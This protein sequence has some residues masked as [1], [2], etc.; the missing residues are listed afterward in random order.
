MLQ[1]NNLQ[2]E[3]SESDYRTIRGQSNLNLMNLDNLVARFMSDIPNEI[4]K[5]SILTDRLS[6]LTV[7]AGNTYFFNKGGD[8]KVVENSG[9]DFDPELN[10]I[11]LKPNLSYKLEPKEGTNKLITDKKVRVFNTEKTKLLS[12][13]D[14]LIR[15]VPINIRTEENNYKY[16]LA[17]TFDELTEYNNIS[18][19]LNEKTESYPHITEVYYINSRREK[20]SVKILNN[21]LYDLDLDLVK[22]SSNIYSIDIETISA[23]NIYI[24]LEDNLNELI[25][26]KLHINYMEYPSK[27]SI[28]F[29]AIREDKP[30][31][32]VG[33]ESQGTVEASKLELSYNNKDWVDIDISNTYAL[34]KKSKVIAYNTINADSIKTETDVKVMYLRV[35]LYAISEV[36]TPTAKVDRNTYA[37]GEFDT[38]S[39]KYNSYSLYEN[40]TGNFYGYL[41]NQNRF[42]FNDFYDHGEYLIIDNRYYAKGFVETEF[43]KTKESQYIYAP[44]SLKTKEIKISGDRVTFNHI[45]ISTKEV[46]STQTERVEKNLVDSSGL[47]FVIPLKETAYNSVYYLRQ[48]TKEIEVNLS[49]GHINSAIDVLY[50]VGEGD[51]FLLDS[52]KNLV[53]KLEVKSYKNTRYVSLLDTNLFEEMENLSRLYPIEPLKDYETGLIDNQ[54]ESINRD[55]DIVGYVLTT[56]K[57]YTKDFIS[58]KNTNYSEIISDD[59]YKRSFTTHTEMVSKYVKQQKLLKSGIV[60]GSIAIEGVLE[61]PFINGYTEFI[62]HFSRELTIE[63]R[64]NLTHEVELNEPKVLDKTFTYSFPDNVQDIKVSLVKR[65]SR[66]Y[67]VL[68]SD[69]PLDVKILVSYTYENIDPKRLYSIDYDRGIIH[70]SEKIDSEYRITYQS[71]NLISTGKKARQME[72]EEFSEVNKKFNI[73]NHRDNSSILFLYKNDIQEH[74]NTTPV[75]QDMKINYILKDDLSL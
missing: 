16:T 3:Y 60:R 68:S 65:G 30:I 74:R 10:S 40:S 53:R 37:S 35:T 48:G 8:L 21:N 19:K 1:K 73:R 52:F 29:E 28:V 17:L 38:S 58:D 4:K 11:K 13:D 67:V 2:R 33:I 5:L 39:L 75:L 18:I 34:E 23:D 57:M 54:L 49:T 56:K 51:V 9:I 24:V 32:K 45:D 27:G 25:I 36:Y 70:F 12:L 47:R 43:S 6:N 31:M 22:N 72:G 26:D 44:V 64:G 46:Y 63:A 71:D 20:K 42:N 66:F 55:R 14:M 7:I 50:F 62:E 41:S 61:I 59:D 15:Q 69:R